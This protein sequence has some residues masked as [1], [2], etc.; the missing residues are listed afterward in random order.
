MKEEFTDTERFE[1]DGISLQDLQR[2]LSDQ[3]KWLFGIPIVCMFLAAVGVMIAKPK[4]EATAVIQIGQIGQSG[5][6][7]GLQL[8]EPPA[9]AIER[10]KMKSFEDGVLASLKI[11]L[12]IGDPIAQLF[13]TSLSLKAL[14]TTDLIQVRVRGY[15][16]EQAASW[17]RAVVDQISAAHEKLTQPTVERLNKQLAELKKQMQMIE[18]ERVNLAKIV[19]ITA[20]KS[21]V[22]N[23]SENLL[24]SNLLV[25]KNAELRDFEMRLLAVN[26]QLTSIR[27]YPTSLVDR[28]YV[29]EQPASPKKSLMI[30]LAAI[31][32]LILGVIVAFLRNY[33]QAGTD[34]A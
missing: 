25:Q 22:S 31:V 16:P 34:R 19:S 12:T 33:W 26:E 30:M 29:P 23:F 7:Q 5:A 9:R 11:P 2:V 24:F 28:V 3:R 13:R 1:R 18:N 32:G 4:W 14:G 17:G 21:G 8:I 10:M 20:A 27:A 15:S 6:G